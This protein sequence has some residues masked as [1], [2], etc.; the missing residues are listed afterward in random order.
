MLVASLILHTIK[1]VEANS[2]FEGSNY[3]CKALAYIGIILSVKFDN[4]HFLTS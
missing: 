3:E 1:E 4:C 2:N